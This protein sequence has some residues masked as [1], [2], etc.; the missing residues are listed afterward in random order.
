MERKLILLLTTL[1]IISGC[2]IHD[3]S[4]NNDDISNNPS[5]NNSIYLSETSI[6]S[7][8]DSISSSSII[9]PTSNPSSPIDNS[10]IQ[11]PSI[12]VVSPSV[13]TS[14]SVTIN[15]ISYTVK[16]YLEK[17]IDNEY[18]L[19]YEEDF[20]ADEFITINLSANNYEG[21]I[22]DVEHKEVAIKEDNKLF[23]FY[24]I[25]KAYKLSFVSNSNYQIED[26]YLKHGHELDN[27]IIGIKEGYAFYNWCLDVNL[28]I[29]FEK[30]PME[31][32]VIY[33]SYLEELKPSNF[34]Y[35]TSDEGVS[36]IGSNFT[37]E[38]L[39]IPS[40][41]GGKPVISLQE[42]CFIDKEYKNIVLPN[43]LKTINKS[44]FTYICN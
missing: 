12:D 30:M 5:I 3:V 11:S 16:H 44:V 25:R 37:G 28:S 13:D 42:S 36:I 1:S 14:T 10:T 9:S 7:E 41:I 24:Y 38:D 2:S 21:Y 19:F 27:N 33:A 18:E 31:D 26:I 35:E 8:M 4:I 17:E 34:T 40:Y 23:E 39:I 6:P 15:K 20:I 43:T 29:P 32:T 22:P